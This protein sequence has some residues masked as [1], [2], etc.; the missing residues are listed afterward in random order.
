[1]II[2]VIYIS[3]ETIVPKEFKYIK[4]GNDNE[5]HIKFDFSASNQIEFIVPDLT[6]IN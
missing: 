2:L 5:K 6:S 4:L 3:T 1:M